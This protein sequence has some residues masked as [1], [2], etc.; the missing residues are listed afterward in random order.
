[1]I[2]ESK[3]ASELIKFY[4]SG[5]RNFRNANLS[6]LE[7]KRAQL[8]EIDLQGAYMRWIDFQ[9][10]NLKLANLPWA[11]LQKANL[12]DATLQRATLKEA[13]LR[14]ANLQWADLQ[15][16]QLQ[17]ANLFQCRLMCAN[18]R[19][20]SLRLANLEA[21][22]LDKAELSGVDLRVAN[23]IQAQLRN[24]DLK[25]G[26]LQGANLSKANLT[27]ANLEGVNLQGA[28]LRGANLFGANL[29][30]ANLQQA[31]LEEAD[32]TE[33]KLFAANLQG[34]NLQKTRLPSLEN[35]QGASLKGAQLLGTLLPKGKVLDPA[36]L[37]DG[38][39][40]DSVKG[41]K[42][43]PSLPQAP[44]IE[45]PILL[46]LLPDRLPDSQAA[47][48]PDLST[49][50]TEQMLD[51][52]L[53]PPLISLREES[54]GKMDSGFPLTVSEL[55]GKSEAPV[56]EVSVPSPEPKSLDLPLKSVSRSPS[57]A[58]LSQKDLNRSHHYR[59]RGNA[60]PEEFL[61]L[62]KQRMGENGYFTSV[63]LAIAKRRG[64]STLRQQLLEAY[65]GRC[66]MTD[67]DVEPIL[68]VAFLQPN[69]PT[70]SSDPSYGLLLRA[71]VHTLFDLHLIVVEPE[72]FQI[73]VAPNLRDTIYG[74]LH[75]QPLRLTTMEKFKPNQELLKLRLQWSSWFDG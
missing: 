51:P 38:F 27:G 73:M 5:Q 33:A 26:K 40:L 74:S 68:E 12:S 67:C 37:E 28:N 70:Q 53:D 35:M 13:N 63:S 34:A 57:K 48:S 29:Q 19:G 59:T 44:E 36:I 61:E 20:A 58:H 25:Q 10:A 75:Q 32:L 23:L 15:E 30:N 6:G 49:G 1:M 54:N 18:F 42:S 71:D 65:Q 11:D 39:V 72:T 14:K 3:S 4:T 45:S 8:P 46:S 62:I 2:E 43:L 41:V 60:E 56:A 55:S 52:L 64:P 16:A 47:I 66:S 24:A 17:G 21:A 31:N 22:D 69:Q 50:V 9:G 7:L